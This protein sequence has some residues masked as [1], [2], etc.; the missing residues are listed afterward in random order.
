MKSLNLPALLVCLIMALCPAAADAFSNL[1]P[2]SYCAGSP[3][4]LVDPNGEEWDYINEDGSKLIVCDLKFA[5]REWFTAE[6]INAYQNAITTRFNALITETSNGTIHGEVR[7]YSGAQDLVQNID[8]DFL[9]PKTEGTT[10]NMHSYVNLI[11]A[12]G[13]LRSVDDVATDAIHEML[14]T[15]RLAHPFELTQTTDT[16]LISLG[17][18]S[19][20]TTSNTAPNIV[21]NIMNYSGTI[22]DG[23]KPSGTPTLTSGQLGF[24]IEGILLQKQGYGFFPNR[25]GSLDTEQY[26]DQINKYYHDY[27]EF[28]GS[29]VVGR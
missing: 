16:E 22:I 9:D 21:D 11:N 23:K 7:F 3:I 17:G 20:M 5:I 26:I 1:S 4:N 13:E 6:Q 19:Y 29:P 8:L 10:I 12:N 14:H 25:D 24:I 18:N 15:L 27:W 28:P 2:Y